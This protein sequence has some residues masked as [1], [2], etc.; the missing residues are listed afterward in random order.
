MGGGIP[1]KSIHFS[2][3]ELVIDHSVQVDIGYGING[4]FLI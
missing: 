2:P 3:V 4:A 1:Q